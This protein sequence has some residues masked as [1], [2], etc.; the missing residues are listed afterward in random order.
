MS[1]GLCSNLK[2]YIS[3]TSFFTTAN[4]ATYD[5]FSAIGSCNNLNA[6]GFKGIWATPSKADWLR[7]ICSEYVTLWKMALKARAID[8]NTI[9]KAILLEGKMEDHLQHS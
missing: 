4:A 2:D 5:T 9:T 6:D 8:G 7:I 1:F 3:R